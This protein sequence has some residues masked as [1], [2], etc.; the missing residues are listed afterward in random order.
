MNSRKFEYFVCDFMELLGYGVGRVIQQTKDDGID[1]VVK[2][3]KLGSRKIF[4]QAK[5]HARDNSISVAEI[6]NL[7]GL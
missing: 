5:C 7:L 6:Q 4:L 2:E 1:S 3:D